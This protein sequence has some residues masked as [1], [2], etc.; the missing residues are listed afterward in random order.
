MTS[1][2]PSPST[3]IVEEV[4]VLEPLPVEVKTQTAATIELDVNDNYQKVTKALSEEKE[5]KQ[6]IKV[7]SRE[8]SVTPQDSNNNST[9]DKSVMTSPSIRQVSASTPVAVEEKPVNIEEPVRKVSSV[10]GP[11]DYDDGQ[12]SPANLEGKKYYTR[13][14]LLKLKDLPIAGAA[15]SMGKLPESVVNILMKNNRDLLTNTLT[16][17]MPAQGM[18]NSGM[19]RGGNTFDPINSVAPKFMTMGGG[20]GGSRNLYQKRPSQ[21]GNNKQQVPGNGRG[22]QAGIIKLTLSLQDDVKLNEAS[23][24]WKP[25]HLIKKQDMTE[26]ERVTDDLLS[27]FRSMLNKLTAE[28]FDLLVEQV[29]LYKIDTSERLDGVISLVFE[30]AISEPKFAPTYAN[31]CKEVAFIT[32]A[33]QG[34]GEKK[35]TLKA[36]LITQCQKEFERHKEESIIFNDIEDKLKEI[37]SIPDKDKREEQKARL[38]EEHY[39]VRQRANGTVKFIGELYKIDMLTSKIMRACID[40]LL[41]EVTEEKIERVCKLLTTIGK[42]MEHQDGRS[43][44]DIYFHQLKDMLNPN[45]KIIKSSRIKFEIQNLEDLRNSNWKSRR[46]DLTPKTIDQMQMEADQEQQM[47]NYQT[48][49]NAKDDRQRGNQGGYNNNNNNNNN[50][51]RGQQQDSEGWSVQQNNKSRMPIQFNKISI[52]LMASEAKLG[53]PADYQK[54]AMPPNTNKYSGLPLDTDPD[55]PQRYG[56]AG[57]G[58]SKNSSMERSGDRGSRMYGNGGSDGRYSGRSSGSNQGS[59]N[60]SQIRS[61]DNSDAP[62]GPSRSLQAPRH[63]QAPLSSSMSFS[64]ALKNPQKATTTSTGPVKQLT[65][66]EFAKNSK[67]MLLIVEAYR[68]DK[69][70]LDMAI[71][72]LNPVTVTKDVLVEVYNKYLDRKNS[73]R[74]NLMLLLCEMLKLNKLSRDENR[75]ALIETM[76]LAPEMICDVPRVYEYIAQFLG[77]FLNKSLRLSASKNSLFYFS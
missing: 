2:S 44:F 71:T 29:K 75:A 11:I 15:P 32:T 58:G 19:Q 35:N 73:D 37:D 26:E 67:E 17:T 7:T 51:R 10:E 74:E 39:R 45:H 22:S 46:Q 62:G 31:L 40:M 3:P 68:N 69:L 56:G 70:T 43:S 34:Q 38:E 23:N 4:P 36:K 54:F 1:V 28:N 30:K 57:P 16:Q 52:P 48:R 42:K 66:E 13:D 53:S 65:S 14:Q 33:P 21:Q 55:V 41:Q 9:D 47:M 20:G 25:S 6:P 8:V 59:R 60:S 49:Q 24:A 77:K 50:N 18:S 64:G 63:Q 72:K 12:W 61:R 27:R 76:E 5:L